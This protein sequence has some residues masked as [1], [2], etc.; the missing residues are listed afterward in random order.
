M[1]I[2]LLGGTGLLGQA[3]AAQT[4]LQGIAV[5]T[6][7]RNG[8]DV[9]VDIRDEAAL[10][11]LLERGG[12]DTV[13]N[14]AAL[15]DLAECERSPQQAAAVN[16]RPV[17]ILSEF[18]RQTGAYLV[19]ISTDHYYTGDKNR[20][21]GELEPVTLVNEYARSKYAGER[22]ALQ[23]PAALVIR[24]NIVGFRR[25][26]DAPTFVEW[27]FRCLSQGKPMSL[28]DD[29]YTSSIDVRTF[30]ILLL[31]AMR[32]KPSGVLNLA[33]RQVASK[34]QFIEILARKSGYRLNSPT[35]CSVKTLNGPPRAE[36]LG[37]DVSKAEA[38]LGRKLPGLEAV[39]DSLVA[40]HKETICVT[41]Q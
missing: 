39:T 40:E 18:A 15:T 8:A 29:F 7:A 26:S 5:Q 11:E 38:M 9:R 34:R 37:L 28:F 24:T 3:L 30:S 14:A 32:A 13:I 1:R 20:Q 33:S 2:L 10:R 36:S 16:E 21:H 23:D 22:A 12:F 19:Q 41:T 25:K 4:R 27:V 6:A 31:D 17:R 35:I